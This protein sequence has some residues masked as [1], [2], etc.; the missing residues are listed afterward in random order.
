MT[1][2]SA[3][4][5][6]EGEINLGFCPFRPSSVPLFSGLFPK[7]WRKTEQGECSQFESVSDSTDMKLDNDEIV[8]LCS[9]SSSYENNKDKV[10]QP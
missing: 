1:L 9:G 2:S 8:Y 10:R 5:V 4:K 7:M 3:L 6:E